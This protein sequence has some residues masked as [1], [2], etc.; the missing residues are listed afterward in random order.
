M[1]IKIEM[2]GKGLFYLIVSHISLYL[3]YCPS[4]KILPLM[5][6]LFHIVCRESFDLKIHPTTLW[7]KIRLGVNAE[8]VEHMSTKRIPS[9]TQLPLTICH[10]LPISRESFHSY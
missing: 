1:E 10:L 3:I 2:F 5:N 8:P 9:V 7:K 4:N 6:S